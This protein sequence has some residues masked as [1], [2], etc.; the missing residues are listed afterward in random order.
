MLIYGITLGFARFSEE[1]DE[2][3]LKG[4]I[5]IMTLHKSKGDEFEYV[6][7]PELSEK[8]LSIDINQADIKSSTTFM[9]AIR[10]FNPKYKVKSELQLKEFSAEES[11]RLFYVAV[12]RAKKKLYI[13]SAFKT[14]SSFGKD[15]ENTPNIVF[16]KILYSESPK[17]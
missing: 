1:E 4:K 8:L 14:K 15:I 11:M 3:V 9:E 2:S 17:E 13:T 12:T 7:M 5:Q 6:F 16:E 10:G